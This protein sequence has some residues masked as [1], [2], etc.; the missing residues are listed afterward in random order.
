[1]QSVWLLCLLFE[2]WE[3]VAGRLS[4]QKQT[5]QLF[6]LFNKSFIAELRK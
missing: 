5:M 6:K 4:E 1:M 3:W 2:V